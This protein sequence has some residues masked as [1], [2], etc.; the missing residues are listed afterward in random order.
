MT[1]PLQAAN[2]SSLRLLPNTLRP[3]NP[4]KRDQIRFLSTA[5]AQIKIT[6]TARTEGRGR[7]EGGWETAAMNGSSERKMTHTLLPHT[8]SYFRW[9]I[10]PRAEW[11]TSRVETRWVFSTGVT[12]ACRWPRRRPSSWMSPYGLGSSLRFQPAVGSRL[13]I[14]RTASGQNLDN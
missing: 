9:R 3:S 13:L 5:H 2:T 12:A 11:T 4:W 8:L 7:R 6:T 10:L 14:C 1:L